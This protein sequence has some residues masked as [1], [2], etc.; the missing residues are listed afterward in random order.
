MRVRRPRESEARSGGATLAA[1]GT[2]GHRA[3][4]GGRSLAALVVAALAVALTA[5]GEDEP[6]ADIP[7][8]DAT[9]MLDQL[10]QARAAAEAGDCATAQSA[11]DEFI[12][13]VNLLRAEDVETDV[14]ESMRNAGFKLEELINAQC[15]EPAAVTET[16]DEGEVAPPEET[17]TEEPAT[18]EEPPAEEPTEPE[19]ETDTETEEDPP[20]QP[21]GE[22]EVTPPPDEGEEDGND[23]GDGGDDGNDEG[24]GGGDDSG[25][26]GIEG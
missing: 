26:G 1:M 10:D 25:T 15:E 4:P 8:T 16:P 13:M 19:T 18:E 22:G 2:A 5:C 12:A 17:T 6:M 11:V 7:R 9:A 14:K 3:T 20:E 23:E 24:D 21:P